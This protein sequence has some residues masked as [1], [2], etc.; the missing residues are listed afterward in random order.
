MENEE[1]LHDLISPDSIRQAS[2]KVGKAAT[3]ITRQ[4]QRGG[5]SAEMVIALCRAY[6]RQPTQGLIETGFLKPWET[7]G[8]AIPYALEQSTNQQLLDEILRRSDPE[9]RYLFGAEGED[10]VIGLAEDAVDA[11]VFTLPRRSN[12][13]TPEPYTDVPH[14]WNPEEVAADSSPDEDKLREIAEHGENYD[15]TDPNQI[16]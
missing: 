13:A 5:L 11:K 9:A 14:G 3:T 4:L 2:L 12:A 6:E 7:E 15:W 16:P 1:W 10:D 8:V